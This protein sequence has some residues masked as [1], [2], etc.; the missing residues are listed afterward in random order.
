MLWRGGEGTWSTRWKTT[1][2][3]FTLICC[4]ASA[5]VI[6]I[7]SCCGSGT[8]S[9][10]HDVVVMDVCKDGDGLAQYQRKPHNDV[11]PFSTKEHTGNI[12][13]WHLHSTKVTENLCTAVYYFN[14]PW[15][16]E[17]HLYVAQTPRWMYTC[18]SFITC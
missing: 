9:D 6:V 13:Q 11:T 2:A 17:L 15:L 18:L 12:S 14:K 3:A 7:S 10:C 1:W 4:T 8:T 16:N 5:E